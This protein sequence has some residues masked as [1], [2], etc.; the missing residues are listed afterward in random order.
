MKKIISC[1][2]FS[3]LAFYAHAHQYD[4]E[5]LRRT[6]KKNLSSF[7]ECVKKSKNSGKEI[8]GKIVLHWTINK[9]GQPENAIVETSEIKDDSFHSCML[10]TL[11]KLSFE[12]PNK[13]VTAEVRFPFVFNAKNHK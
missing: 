10:E 12:K 7:H 8:N 3:F 4:K 11:N 5:Q 13:N 1:F 9:M 2:V 6:I